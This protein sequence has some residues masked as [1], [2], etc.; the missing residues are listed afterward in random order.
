MALLSF[1]LL[2]PL[3]KAFFGAVVV[4][5]GSAWGGKYSTSSKFSPHLGAGI[6]LRF[7]TPLGPIRLDYAW[8]SE[9]PRTHFSIG[10]PF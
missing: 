3:E 6:G 4:D 9:G 10:H 1:D 5:Y 8:G 7:E 2:V